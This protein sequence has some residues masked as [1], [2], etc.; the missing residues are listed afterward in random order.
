MGGGRGYSAPHI[1]FATVTPGHRS[2]RAARRIRRLAGLDAGGPQ[3][4]PLLLRELATLL[5]LDS[6]GYFYLDAA[7]MP[8]FY[9]EAPEVQAIVPLYLDPHMQAA[10]A[11]VARPYAQAARED[12]GPQLRAQLVTVPEP[13]FWASDYY[14][15]LLRPAGI[16]E[17]MSLVLRQLDGRPLGALK[18]Y[19]NGRRHGFDRDAVAC[20]AALE[21]FIARL[22]TP[23]APADPQQPDMPQ[24][25]ALLVTSQQGR[26][27]WQ[28]PH[29]AAL[30]ALAF[31][32]QGA[33]A[34]LPARCG[35]VLDR[36]RRSRSGQD[37]AEPPQAR[38]HDARGS[39]TLRA[40]WLDA[41][42]A[43]EAAVAL[44][45]EHHRPWTV[46][47][48]E[49]LQ[50]LGLPERQFELAYWLAQGHAEPRIAAHLGVS[51]N[52]LVYHRRRLY[53]RLA[54]HSRKELVQRLEAVPR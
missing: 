51:M 15:L 7:G 26:V 30:L 32:P 4:A 1:L 43:G 6:S 44:E 45:L 19:R 48:L 28:S 22:L 46:R 35:E 34:G 10:E 2:T 8:D 21:P 9:S 12:F 50:D 41:P 36:L 40:S 39:F 29:A 42:G 27:L 5:A 20:L 18:L 14:N 3:F 17:C 52:T 47:V 16:E 11:E 53:E 49:Q 25:R 33:R 54:V 31:G 13:V 37:A 38:W 23:R 24:G